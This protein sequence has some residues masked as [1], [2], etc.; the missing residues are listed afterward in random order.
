LG[1]NHVIVMGEA[2]HF[3]FGVLIDADEYYFTRD[4]LPT[5]GMCSWSS[6]L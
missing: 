2:G 6:D 3:K 5:K 1:P 4:R